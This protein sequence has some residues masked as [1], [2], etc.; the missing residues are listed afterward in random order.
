M[1]KKPYI[2]ASQ[3]FEQAVTEKG[4]ERYVLRLYVA[5]N[6]PRSQSAIENIHKIC[7][8]HLK[9]RY[10][11]EVID[12]YQQPSLARGEQIIAAPTL[13]KYLPLPLRK[14]IGDLSKEERILVGLD[15]VTLG[16]AKPAHD[17]ELD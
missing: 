7:E 10:Q 5:G 1:K 8:E 11:L 17:S 15:L 4:N 3:A 16:S 13:V 6:T 12:I 14:M 9:G 2:E